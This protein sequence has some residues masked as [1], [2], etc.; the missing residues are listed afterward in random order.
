MEEAPDDSGSTG[1][2][3][4]HRT[5]KGD[6]ELGNSLDLKLPP[7]SDNGNAGAYRELNLKADHLVL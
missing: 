5:Q 7:P 4:N 6:S 3:L 1:F 2:D